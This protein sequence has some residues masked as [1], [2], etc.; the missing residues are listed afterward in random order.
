MQRERF[1]QPAEFFPCIFCFLKHTQTHAHIRS[2]TL[3]FLSLSV[4]VSHTPPST[5]CQHFLLFD[6]CFC[7]ASGPTA[8]RLKA[9]IK[10]LSAPSNLCSHRDV[11]FTSTSRVLGRFRVKRLKVRTRGGVEEARG[12]G[13]RRRRNVVY[14]GRQQGTI[15]Y[16][17]SFSPSDWPLE[18]LHQVTHCQ[19]EAETY[20]KKVFVRFVL[21]GPLMLSN[22]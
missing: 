12:G 22:K 1:N 11:G 8:K 10:V 2:H 3:S 16:C 18:S 19:V 15:V 7:I 13:S 14:N 21:F 17:C 5:R 4:S 6:L 20:V 9:H